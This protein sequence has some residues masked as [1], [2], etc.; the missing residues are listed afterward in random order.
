M[1]SFMN[2]TL[3]PYLVAALTFTGLSSCTTTYDS[4]GR[5]V[6]TVDPGTAAAGAAVAGVAGYAIGRNSDNDKKYYRGG[7]YRRSYGGHQR[8]SPRRW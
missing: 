4:Y 3:L 2:K 1:E 8:H 6:Q 5:P 7:N